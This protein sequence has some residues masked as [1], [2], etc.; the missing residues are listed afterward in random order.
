[1]TQRRCSSV[2]TKKSP[3]G[4]YMQPFSKSTAVAQFQK[5]R[6]SKQ[7]LVLPPYIHLDIASPGTSTSWSQTLGGPSTPSEYPIEN[8]L[9]PARR[10]RSFCSPAKKT[11]IDQ[12]KRIYYRQSWNTLKPECSTLVSIG[13]AA[14]TARAR[15]PCCPPLGGCAPPA[16]GDGQRTANKTSTIR[17]R[18]C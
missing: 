8:T 6:T 16:L 3:K 12:T 14:E 17:P 4:I 2:K 10:M 9:P 7:L 18:E 13:A 5:M 15:T 11:S 1:M